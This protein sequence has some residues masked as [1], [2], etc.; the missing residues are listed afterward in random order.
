M[1]FWCRLFLLSEHKNIL[2]WFVPPPL[3]LSDTVTSHWIHL[4]RNL[5]GIF[6]G[7]RLSI[8]ISLY[9]FEQRFVGGIWN[10]IELC[11]LRFS[12]NTNWFPFLQT[13]ILFSVYLC[14]RASDS[15]VH[16]LRWS[17]GPAICINS[18]QAEVT[19]SKHTVKYEDIC[20]C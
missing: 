16:I 8:D 6:N 13:I 12:W 14:S 17:C 1:D 3:R 20:S 9:I 2:T 11:L 18:P 19:N 15:S 4:S 5:W 7:I 10:W